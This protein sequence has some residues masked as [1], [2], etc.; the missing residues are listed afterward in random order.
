MFRLLLI[1]VCI[2]LALGAK[3]G[4]DY[5]LKSSG[6]DDSTVPVATCAVNEH[7]CYG[8]YDW[9]WVYTGTATEPVSGKQGSTSTN[10]ASSSGAGYAATYDLFTKLDLTDVNT[11]D[12]N[13]QVQ[14]TVLN[15]MC[16]LSVGVCFYFDSSG[17]VQNADPTYKAYAFDVS[18][19]LEG[20]SG[21]GFKNS[22]EAALTAVTN[23]LT[24]NPLEAKACGYSSTNHVNTAIAN[25]VI[26]A[27]SFKL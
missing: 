25:D 3:I 6:C 21:P 1:V 20:Q 10:Y 12:C 17:A 16:T 5:P 18:K 13:C 22:T 9:E 4:T 26:M 23:M 8:F 19:S 27:M 24:A 2:A 14:Q 15:Q 7:I 11:Y